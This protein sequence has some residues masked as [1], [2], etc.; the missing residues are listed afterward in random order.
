[1][2]LSNI[3][4][5][6]LMEIVNTASKTMTKSLMS[7][8]AN[9]VIKAEIMDITPEFIKLKLADN[10]VINARSLVIPEAKLVK[11]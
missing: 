11:R 3:E 1:M 2:G 10:S 8:K 7:L 6:S 5:A 9:D 4:Y